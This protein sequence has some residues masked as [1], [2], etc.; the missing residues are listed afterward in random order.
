VDLLFHARHLFEANAK[1]QT[2]NAKRKIQL[3]QQGEA[4]ANKK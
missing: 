4:I 2:P 1:R 3:L